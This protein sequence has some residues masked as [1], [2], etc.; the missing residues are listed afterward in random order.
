M[1]NDNYDVN[2]ICTVYTHVYA[3]LNTYVF[4]WYAMMFGIYV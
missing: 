3:M 4:V 1:Y 2:M